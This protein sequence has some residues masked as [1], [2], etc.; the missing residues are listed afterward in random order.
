M[1]QALYTRQPVE[2]LGAPLID[3]QRCRAVSV[4]DITEGLKSFAGEPLNRYS[5]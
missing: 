4:N 2:T 5:S 1:A 3:Q